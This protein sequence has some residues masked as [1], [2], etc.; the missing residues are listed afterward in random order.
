MILS[1]Q[2]APCFCKE[3]F[4]IY[5]TIGPANRTRHHNMG[6]TF[7]NSYYTALE[8]HK[9]SYHKLNKMPSLLPAF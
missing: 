3:L 7:Y 1:S 4:G 6:S 9:T 2:K 8:Y 5:I